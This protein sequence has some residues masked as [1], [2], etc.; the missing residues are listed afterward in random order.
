VEVVSQLLNELRVHVVLRLRDL[1]FRQHFAQSIADPIQV[2]LLIEVGDLARI[3]KVIDI[4]KERLMHNL[5]VRHK[6][7]CLFR[8]TPSVQEPLS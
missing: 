1:L 6:E 4:L 7:S 2:F 3:Q 5:R 8:I